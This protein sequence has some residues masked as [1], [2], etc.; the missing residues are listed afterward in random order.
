MCSNVSSLRQCI[1]HVLTRHYA[2]LNDITQQALPDLTAK[3]FSNGMIASTSNPSYNNLVK[4]FESS[5][6]FVNSQDAIL[7]HCRKF[8]AAFYSC[9][10]PLT[11]AA[12]T[13][14]QDI[15]ERVREKLGVEF[16]ITCD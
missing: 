4:S 8:F 1:V 6:N 2:D 15:T 5:L 12:E 16:L 3:L 10:G 11:L 7:E 9:G 14:T 13:V